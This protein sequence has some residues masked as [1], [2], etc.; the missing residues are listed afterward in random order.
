MIDLDM[1]EIFMLRPDALTVWEDEE[2]KKRLSWYHSVMVDEKP[3]KFL[4]ARRVEPEENPYFIT[5]EGELWRIHEKASRE[6]ES[7]FKEVAGTVSSA[8]E[9][10]R[11]PEPKY[12]YLDVKIALA[13][14]LMDPCRLCERR[15]MAR[16]GS[17]QPG[18][19]LVSRKC[20]VHSAFLHVGEE[21]PLVPSGTIFYGGCNFKC[22]FCQ[23]YDISQ[24]NARGGQVLSSMELARVQKALRL[25]GARNINHVGG[26][27]TPHIP[28][29]LESLK[30]LDVN[31]PQLW[32]S[33]MYMSEESM[34]LLLDVIDIWLPDLKYGND[35]CAWRLSKV[36]NYW[37][38][39]TRNIKLAHDSGDMIIRH[40]VLPNHLECCTRPV[41]KWI[42]ENATRALVN[43]MDQYHPE[44]LVLKYPEKYREIARRLRREEILEAYRIADEYKLAYRQVS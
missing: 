3:A 19:C 10:M 39:A 21:A 42:A 33:N 13:R 18:V 6:F 34:R 28:F 7:V 27:P 11:R 4:I 37:A 15:C 1:L 14:K 9:F 16:R 31:V 8:S 36:R 17:D 32:N 20:I 44:H 2:V 30:Y 35:E 12:S 43:V 22:V 41:L 26:E 23:N 25:R 5:D 24:V 40:L 29:I 38:I